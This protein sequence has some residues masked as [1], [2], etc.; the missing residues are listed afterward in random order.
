MRSHAHVCV[1]VNTLNSI[2]RG[3]LSMKLVFV[4]P[5]T[6]LVYLLGMSLSIDLLMHPKR[7]VRQTTF[8]MHG[9]RLQRNAFQNVE[10]YSAPSGVVTLTWKTDVRHFNMRRPRQRAHSSKCRLRSA[11]SLQRHV[12]QRQR[13]TCSAVRVHAAPKWR[14]AKNWHWGSLG[15]AQGHS[16]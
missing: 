7:L 4:Y 9:M 11:K 15:Y 6:I 14:S 2:N 8:R 13:V 5:L 1:C 12:M 10:L 3:S 16:V